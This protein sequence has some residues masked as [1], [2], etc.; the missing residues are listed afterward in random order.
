MIVTQNWC[1]CSDPKATFNT[2]LKNY[3]HA[4]E[5]HGFVFFVS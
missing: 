1:H 5:E 4:F 3:F 2:K